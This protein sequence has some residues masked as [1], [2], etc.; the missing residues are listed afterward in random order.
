LKPR[1]KG[2]STTTIRLVGGKGGVGK[3]TLAAAWAVAAAA[4]GA[5]TLVISTDPAPSLG[6]ALGVA[7]SGAP[8][9]VPAAGLLH[10]L[11][12]DS[13]KSFGR[14]LKDRA[15]ALEAIAVR[16][17]W[18]DESDV[19]L[20]LGLS[21]PGIDELASLLEIL[22]HQRSGRYD[23]I[24]VDTAPTGH[25][26]RMLAMPDT[27]AGLARVFDHM[28]AK[29]HAIVEALRGARIEDEGDA[30]IRGLQQDAVALRDLLRDRETTSTVLVTLPEAL[31]VQETFDA[32]RRLDEAGIPLAEIAF[33]RL[34]PAPPGPCLWCRTRRTAERHAVSSLVSGLPRFGSARSSR[35]R[36]T[37]IE[38]AD[39]E[40]IGVPA[41]RQLARGAG[42]LL[43][44][45][46]PS[47]ARQRI[48]SH[49][50]S[51][52]GSGECGFDARDVRLLMFGG[53]GGVGKT[54]CA[55]AAALNVSRRH[56]GRR[57]LLVSTD[58][59]HS[60]S[61][62]LCTHV[63]DAARRIPGGPANLE[64]RE[65]DAT[66]AFV[67]FRENYSAAI[68]RVFDRLSRG[69]SVDASH[70]RRVLHDLLEL[71]PPGLDEIAAVLGVIDLLSPEAYDTLIVDTAPTGHAL[72]LLE[73]PATVQDWT[74]ALMAILLKYQ[75]VIGVGELGATLLRLSRRLG[76]LR[77]LL[78]NPR[79]THFVI[80][81]RAAALPGA[82]TRR[83]F[84]SLRRL[85]MHVPAIVVN[86]AGGGTCARCRRATRRERALI[87]GLMP[88]LRRN[89]RGTSMLLAPAMV[90]APA[91]VSIL[92]K[93]FAAWRCPEERPR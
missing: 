47:A 61:D 17:T 64:V 53:K 32:V 77:A 55:A 31:S 29:H 80:V 89:A 79:E 23:T 22:R 65:L 58:P 12:V 27:L 15:P 49:V 90:P 86:A 19:R 50:A 8:R 56:P 1:S 93:W 83:L 16:G 46:R 25:T 44:V 18:L 5:R 60:L 76:S 69:S 7:L 30:L 45:K 43:D 71:A 67:A 20:L 66:L 42:R 92:E 51:V 82:E 4:R 10:A 72:R 57:V 81:T 54:T 70:D 68:D 91:G 39:R 34:T 87:S 3:T 21:L 33:N 75:T 88:S 62:V 40:P 85:R 48:P 37:G 35:P 28:Q 63:D 26:L 74:K 9:P 13:R 2:T 84:R 11:E 73:T 38:S 78:A 59:A 6:D 24:V 41:L 52:A 14:W 36:T